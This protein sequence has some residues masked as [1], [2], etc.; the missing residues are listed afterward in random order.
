MKSNP[1]VRDSRFIT[2]RRGGLAHEIPTITLLALWVAVFAEHVLHLFESENPSDPD[3]IIATGKAR[4]W[5]RKADGDYSIP[6]SDAVM[7]GAAGT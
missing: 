5:S 3:R 6:D 1:K 4:A 7:H 2:F